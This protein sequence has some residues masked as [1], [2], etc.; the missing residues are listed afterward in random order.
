MS[1][2]KDIEDSIPPYKDLDDILSRRSLKSPNHDKIA[3]YLMSIN[4]EDIDN[5]TRDILKHDIHVRKSDI[6]EVYTSLVNDGLLTNNERFRKMITKKQGKSEYGEVTLTV[7]FSPH[8]TIHENYKPKTFDGGF[9]CKFDCLYCPTEPG[10]PKSYPSK[11]PAMLRASRC[12]FFPHWQFYERLITLEKMG[13]VSS[14]GSKI[15]VIILGGTYSSMPMEYREDFMRFLYASANNY[16]NVFN[17]EDVG[18]LAEETR[19]NKTAN[20]KIVGMVIETRPDCITNE[21][22]YFMRQAFVTKVQIG[23]QHFDNNVLRDI[24]RGATNEDTIKGMK[25]LK[26][27]GFKIIIHLMPRLP[28]VNVELDEWMLNE[29][30]DNQAYRPDGLKIYP[31]IKTEFTHFDKKYSRASSKLSE[32]ERK[33]WL[34]HQTYPEE[35]CK[36]IIIDFKR[37]V[38]KYVRLERIARDIPTNH[39]TIKGDSDVSM[40]HHIMVEMKEKGYKCKCIR[41]RMVTNEE[42]DD[43]E[44]EV[45]PYYAQNG[46]EFFISAVNNTLERPLIGFLRLRLQDNIKNSMFPVLNGDTAYVRQLQVHGKITHVGKDSKHAQHLGIGK[47]LMKYAENIAKSHGYN[48]IAVITA[49]G[50]VGY[51]EKLGYKLEDYYMIKR[52]IPWDMIFAMICLVVYIGYLIYL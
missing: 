39:H 15:E 40:R 50:T 10:M 21:E 18:T 3:K 14:A 28:C 48:K 5:V 38:P 17:P 31:Y 34:N 47:E 2:I 41:C 27:N 44:I 29:C 24:N 7:S 4:Q 30:I 12:K 36:D 11:G 22:L 13:H 8:L 16:P 9:T 19:K 49:A 23:V 26:E 46:N 33:H 37:K 32:K 51:Y 25:K 20:F 43:Y 42:F 6:N 45:E 1:D 52:F 35:Q